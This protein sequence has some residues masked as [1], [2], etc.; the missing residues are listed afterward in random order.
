MEEIQI[1]VFSLNNDLCGA[2]TLQV[3][4]IIRYT[5]VT[6][7][8]EMPEFIEGV[9]NL[10]GSVVPVVNLNRKFNFGDTEITQKTKVLITDMGGNL[11]GFIVNDVVQLEKL[12]EAEI[13]AVPDILSSSC[14]TYLKCVGKKG[15]KI[16]S[17][18]DLGKIISANELEKIKY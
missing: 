10:R 3:S 9:I 11:L 16:I 5:G 8:P 17:V 7:L 15:E 4:Q 2:D 14:N 13:E 12:S 18:L 1:V 6:K